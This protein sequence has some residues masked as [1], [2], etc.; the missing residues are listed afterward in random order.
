MSTV[1]ATF[2]LL[3]AS[4]AGYYQPYLGNNYGNFGPGYGGYGGGVYP[5]QQGP[6]NIH[7]HSSQQ[8]GYGAGI[9]GG[10]P[11]GINNIPLGGVGYGGGYGGGYGQPGIGV[12]YGP[13]IGA[14]YGPGYG[15]VGYNGYRG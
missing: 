12:G 5:G 15:G 6:S 3:G 14:G 13:G 1:T 8:A 4:A 10:Y 2:D 11:V 9:G 7:I